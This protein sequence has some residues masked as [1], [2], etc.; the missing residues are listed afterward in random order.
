[1]TENQEIENFQVD[2]KESKPF[3]YPEIDDGEYNAILKKV[4]LKAGIENKQHE[5][6]DL[7]TW[8]FDVDGKEIK[9]TSSAKIT[10]MSKAYGWIKS[11]TGIEP[12]INKPFIPSSLKD[13]KCRIIVKNEDEVRDFQGTKTTMHKPIVIEVMHTKTK[14]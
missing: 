11:I 8:Y 2:V 6:F 7:M 5:K 14:K 4:T 12:E 1:M 13:S 9:G 10:T 3:E